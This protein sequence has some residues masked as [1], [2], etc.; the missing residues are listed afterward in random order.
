VSR[1]IVGRRRT[2]TWAIIVIALLFALGVA[3]AWSLIAG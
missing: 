3:S 1:R 2:P